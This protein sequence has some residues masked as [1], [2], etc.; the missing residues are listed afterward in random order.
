MPETRLIATLKPHRERAGLSQQGLA[1]R[2]GVSRQAIVAI[3]AGRQ[4][5]STALGLQLAR[6]LGCR[7]EELFRLDD[8]G[9]DAE[10]APA[11]TSA[12]ASPG[13]A[14]TTARLAVG[15]VAGRWVAHRLPLD[16]R[17]A[18]DGVLRSESADGRCVVQPTGDPARLH[19]NVLVAGCAP[20]LGALS[21][22]VGSRFADARVT[23]MEASS[24]HALTLLQRGLIHVAGLHLNADWAG[25]D[26]AAAAR[27]AFPAQRMLIVNLAR[28]RQ[29]IV[30]PAGNPLAL[31]AAADLLRPGLRFAGR[32]AGAGA[33]ELIRRLLS[34]RGDDGGTLAGPIVGG[35]ADVAQLV[36]CG[37]ADAGVAIES[38]ALAAG[39]DFL[40]LCEERFD[41]V[42]PAASAESGPV[43][44]L[45]DTLD[46]PG[47]RADVGH[48][49]GYDGQLSGHVTTLEVAA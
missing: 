3:E 44:R 45:L 6:V 15:H 28:W 8:G 41:L 46:D 31:G 30:A 26:N 16:A 5:P 9:L 49:P 10:L 32:E 12:V 21:R 20:L 42:V 27:R 19:Q 18:T 4:V 38:V 39:L 23:W 2:V 29:G 33:S 36:R 11:L 22:R 17:L 43:R 7:V 47:F 34:G 37:A 13:S 24:L 14:S 40:P 48:L 1:D 35:H 25:E